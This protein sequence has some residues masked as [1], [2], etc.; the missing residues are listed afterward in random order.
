MLDAAAVFISL[1]SLSYCSVKRCDDYIKA[2]MEY[3][4]AIHQ[5]S[6]SFGSTTYDTLPTY[7]RNAIDHP[8]TTSGFTEEELK[9][10]I[11]LLIKLC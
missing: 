1:N 9:T 2:Q 4:P 6:S 10:S 5:K 3:T 8:D 7:I 11:E